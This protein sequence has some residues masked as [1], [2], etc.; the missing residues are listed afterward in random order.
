MELNE[1]EKLAFNMLRSQPDEIQ[2]IAKNGNIQLNDLH[3]YFYRL[4]FLLKA[5]RKKSEAIDVEIRKEE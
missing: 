4:A 3:E 1:T 5:S 2:K